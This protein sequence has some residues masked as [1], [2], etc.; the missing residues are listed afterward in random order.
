MNILEMI[1]PRQQDSPS[2]VNGTRAQLET[3]P[4][5]DLFV[6]KWIQLQAGCDGRLRCPD[7]SRNQGSFSRK[8]DQTFDARMQSVQDS[9]IEGEVSLLIFP[10]TTVD[11]RGE[12]H[13]ADDH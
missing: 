7:I 6:G 13:E 8:L 3:S 2:A 9:K 5:H 11:G 12:A 1:K 10:W 4:E